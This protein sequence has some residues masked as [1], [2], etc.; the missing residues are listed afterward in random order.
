MEEASGSADVLI[1]G[2][3]ADL[4]ALAFNLVKAHVFATAAEQ[5]RIFVWD[6]RR[7]KLLRTTSMGK[8]VLYPLWLSIRSGRKIVQE[9][10]FRVVECRHRHVS[11]AKFQIV[12]NLCF[13]SGIALGFLYPQLFALLPGG[14]R[15]SFFPLFGLYLEA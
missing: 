1:F 10:R 5:D 3:S 15:V 13:A 9:N 7:R 8:E 6:G 12:L 2:H 4:Y 14:P 11:S